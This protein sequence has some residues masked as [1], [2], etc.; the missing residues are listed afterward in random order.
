MHK[1]KSLTWFLWKII[2]FLVEKLR[3]HKMILSLV[4]LFPTHNLEASWHSHK[5][6]I[7]MLHQTQLFQGGGQFPCKICKTNKITM[8]VTW[9]H[10]LDLQCLY[11]KPSSFVVL[12]NASYSCLGKPLPLHASHYSKY[13][14]VVSLL[15]RILSMR[16]HWHPHEVF[17]H[18]PWI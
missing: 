8:L 17:S 12:H 11:E 9:I 14:I 1:I 7:Q 15:I 3:C 5:M 6:W 18:S 10:S 4:N 2:N 16:M 13:P